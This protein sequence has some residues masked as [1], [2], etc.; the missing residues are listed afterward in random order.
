[1]KKIVNNIL[2]LGISGV[3]SLSVLNYSYA[4]K[5]EVIEVDENSI[6]YTFGG[7]INQQTQ[8]ALS[9]SNAYNFPVQFDYLDDDDFDAIV[10]LALTNKDL[11]FGLE[12]IEDLDAMKAGD[13]TA[14]DLAWAK[15]YL[16]SKRNSSS[17]QNY[18]YQI[19]E[20]QA[21]F[22]NFGD[23]GPSQDFCIFD[24]DFDGNPCTE[25]VTRSTVNIIEGITDNGQIF[26]KATAPYLPMT[27]FINS[28]GEVSDTFIDSNGEE[29]NFWLR[30]HGERGFFSPDNGT[31]FFSIIPTEARFGGGVSAIIDM[32][33]NG[34]A[35][36]YESYQL[37]PG[38][39]DYLEEENGGC[40]DPDILD[41]IPYEICQQKVVENLYYL[42]GIKATISDSGEVQSDPLGLLVTPN[43]EDDRS[44]FSRALAINNSGV[45]VGYATGWDNN[46]VVTPQVNERASASYAVVFKEDS[47]GNKVVFD[48]NQQHY[49]FRN[50]IDY[51]IAYDIN[52]N[53]IAVGYARSQDTF[54]QKFFYVDTT[55]PDSEVEVI[56][57]EDFFGSSVSIAYAINNQGIIVGQGQTE[58]HNDSPQNPRRTAAFIYDLSSDTPKI[59]N[60]NNLL[61]CNSPYDIITA[62]D[63][64][65]AGQISATAIMQATSYDEKGEQVFDENGNA[66]MVDVA[67][68]VLLNPIAGEEE[69][70]GDTEEKVERQG[71]GLYFWSLLSLFSLL[72]FRLKR[73]SHNVS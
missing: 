48:L 66:V 57:P 55:K 40:A 21:A 41:D 31:T 25:V 12:E 45:A 30:Q 63:I 61:S 64:N 22:V 4:A 27:E 13:P 69:D 72:A 39:Q 19:V 47:E 56:L 58:T 37:T 70:C 32:N 42:Q 49:G 53:G 14:N 44:F 23:G 2:N 36:G 62:K 68:A 7:N 59:V 5:Y 34:V 73:L 17:N 43:P 46:D 24:T 67:R 9:G 38:A 60:V 26:G 54:V 65:D 29:R 3:I 1:M 15:L 18:E 6:G 71:A 50:F 51:S 11:V 8:I 28:D 16:E 10:T 20:D 33:E 35:V 52:D